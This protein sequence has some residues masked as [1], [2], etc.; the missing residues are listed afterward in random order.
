MSSNGAVIFLIPIFCGLGFLLFVSLIC[1]CV[2]KAK[3]DEARLQPYPTNNLN[4]HRR[5]DDIESRLTGPEG[6]GNGGTGDFP[7]RPG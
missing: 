6:I 1:A 5:M 2:R 7:N 4:G 3:R